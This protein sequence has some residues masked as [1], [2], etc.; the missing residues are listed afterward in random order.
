MQL[1]EY[2]SYTDPIR[3]FRQGLYNY[4]KIHTLFVHHD[5]LEQELFDSKVG[6]TPFSFSPG[7][8]YPVEVTSKLRGGVREPLVVILNEHEGHG[9]PWLS[10]IKDEELK[11]T[12]REDGM[13]ARCLLS[14]YY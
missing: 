7:A 5:D 1:G 6:M 11:N 13:H 8:P 2:S 12:L 10:L 9:W 3:C 4:N 14:Y